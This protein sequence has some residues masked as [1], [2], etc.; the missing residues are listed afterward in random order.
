M[1][2]INLLGVARPAA[3]PPGPPPTV[4]RHMLLLVI[5]L[6]VSFVPVLA[7]R[8]IWGRDV[9]RLEQDLQREKRRQAELAAVKE[10]NL[11]YQQ[12]LNRLQELINTIQTLQNSRV[13]P[14]DFMA[15]LGNTVNR[16]ND[17]Y[18]LTVAS[19]ADRIV[20]RGQANTVESIATFISALRNSGSF[21]D[22]QLRDSY[23]DD[24]ISRVTFKFDLDC[25]YKLPGSATPPAQPGPT[26]A[27][28]PRRAGR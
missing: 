20:I 26:P 16:T 15:S 2:K 7:M 25:V 9:D 4:A 3:A 19:Q 13:G 21:N 14:V 11:R 17:L 27:T 18:L 12:D 5:F 28:A 10:Q 1:I 22:V 23:E 8:W 24:Q 6:I